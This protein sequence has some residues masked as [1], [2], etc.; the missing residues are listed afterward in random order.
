MQLRMAVISSLGFA[1]VAV[2]PTGLAY[3]RFGERRDAVCCLFGRS[4]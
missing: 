4:K 2:S 3:R 1:E